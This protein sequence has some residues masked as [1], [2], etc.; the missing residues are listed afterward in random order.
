MFQSL[1]TIWS[2]IIPSLSKNKLE[3]CKRLLQF[4]IPRK[5]PNDLNSIIYKNKISSCVKWACRISIWNSLM[6]SMEKNGK[7]SPPI[8]L[9]ICFMIHVLRPDHNKSLSNTDLSNVSRLIP[10][11]KKTIR[12]YKNWI[13]F[14]IPATISQA[15]NS[16]K[17]RFPPSPNSIMPLFRQ[18]LRN[19]RNLIR[20]QLSS[21]NLS[22]FRISLVIV[23]KII[24]L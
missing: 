5:K 6:K 10:Y 9:T 17:A 4:L 21:A 23:T 24:I 2:L 13:Y 18:K 7:K 1:K 20:R 8:L 12:A 3:L 16:N 11:N 22:I 15:T 14:K 19:Y